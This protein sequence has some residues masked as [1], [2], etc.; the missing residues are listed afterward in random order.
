MADN[1]TSYYILSGASV[2]ELTATT[3]ITKTTSGSATK[4][5]V[6]FDNPSAKHYTNSPTEIQFGGV[7]SNTTDSDGDEIFNKI[8]ALKSL[9]ES[10][11]PFSI[12]WS[13][14]M[15][16]IDSCVFTNL[17]FAH[18]NR[19]G[20]VRGGDKLA[21]SYIVNM[22]VKQIDISDGESGLGVINPS[23]TLVD[24]LSAAKEYAGSMRQT[25]RGLEIAMP[26]DAHSNIFI[27][28]NDKTYNLEFKFND[29]TKSWY[30]DVYEGQNMSTE[31]TPLP[32]EGFTRTPIKRGVRLKEGTVLPN[33]GTMGGQI[34]VVGYPRNREKLGRNNIGVGKDYAMVFIKD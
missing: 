30:M 31:G 21:S 19:H 17:S 5:P 22:S 3:S 25:E 34:R 9:K 23:P 33:D 13:I 8:A 24:K 29:S 27:S 10:G 12:H 14:G 11:T 20:Q 16:S 28:P 4:Y 18:D 6:D 7:L 15:P 32:T 1:K 2:F 26:N